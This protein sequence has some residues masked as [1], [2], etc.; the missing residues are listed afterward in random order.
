MIGQL[1]VF[2]NGVENSTAIGESDKR[3]LLGQGKTLRAYYYFELA[4]EYQHTYLKD[5][6][7]SAPP[8][9]TEITTEGKP[10]STMS[11]MHDFIL[12]D[13]TYAVN[14]LDESRYYKSF[15]NINVA[16]GILA[17]VYQVM[18]NWPLA[19]ENANAAYGGVV[20]DALSPESYGDGFDDASNPEWIW[21]CIQR[22]DQSSE[23][24][25]S[26]STTSDFI[27][28]WYKATYVN[29][30]FVS[31]FS[32]TD[33]RKL[34]YDPYGSVNWQKWATTKFTFGFESAMVLMR[35]AEMIL[36]EAEA[37]Y[38][39]EDEE[40]AQ[41]LLY[42]LQVNRDPD[43]VK[44]NNTGEALLEEILVE[45]RKELYGEIGVE[46]FD[47]KRLRRGINRDALH[48][49]VV[50]LEPDDIRF[51]LQIPESEILANPNI[52]YDVNDER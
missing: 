7:A 28:G 11:E 43:A 16:H 23:W 38:W 51:V 14:N 13:L 44:A 9:Y 49:I 41:D 50:T 46:W 6:D 24:Y 17:R 26:P 30:N 5:P 21:G 19:E 22:E 47:A 48:R 3:Q 27:N 36:I 2:I 39:Q 37:K 33:V 45:R 40:G 52:D 35:T 34:F 32:D 12:E 29:D 20:E 25:I 42:A 4:L 10:M 31:L 18:G 1:N 8:I 15:V